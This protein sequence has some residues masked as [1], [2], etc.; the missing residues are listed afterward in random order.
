LEPCA[1][2]HAIPIKVIA[3]D[4]YVAEVDADAQADPIVGSDAGVRLGHCLLYLDSTA[5][6]AGKFHQ[7]AVTGDLDDLV[8]LLDDFR[9]E[10]S[11]CAL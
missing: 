11:R 3:I 8:I 4:D 5:D 10:K 1:E 7:D 2:I 6:H 9:I